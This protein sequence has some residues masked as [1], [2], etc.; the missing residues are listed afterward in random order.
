M[1]TTTA[2]ESGRSIAFRS[3]AV[4][5]KVSRNQ[6]GESA[7]VELR[8]DRVETLTQVKAS[9]DKRGS[10]IVHDNDACRTCTSAERLLQA[11]NNNS[12]L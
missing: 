7:P 12:A 11:L 3:I 4:E 9:V 1:C 2:A 10:R 8:A 5:L 6:P